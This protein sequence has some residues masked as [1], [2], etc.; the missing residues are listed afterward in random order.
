MWIQ[1]SHKRYKGKSKDNMA[2]ITTWK[3]SQKRKNTLEGIPIAL[4]TKYCKREN[5]GEWKFGREQGN[6]YLGLAIDVGS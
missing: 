2:V 6:L 4:G 3:G 5:L 1:L